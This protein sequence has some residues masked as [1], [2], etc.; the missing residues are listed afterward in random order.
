MLG[1]RGSGPARPAQGFV[2]WVGQRRT[3]AAR[4][5][6]ARSGQGNRGP[7][8]ALQPERKDAAPRFW[9]ARDRRATPA[10]TAAFS[11]RSTKRH[12]AS[13]DR[14]RWLAQKRAGVPNFK[15]Q[16]QNLEH[17]AD[18]GK[19]AWVE[20]E[21]RILLKRTGNPWRIAVEDVE[22]DLYATNFTRMDGFPTHGLDDGETRT[23]NHWNGRGPR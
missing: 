21:N 17:G 22:K 7:C 19:K 11:T 18:L 14:E 12:D 23:Q 1:L 9:N 15:Q 20:N 3:G 5:V 10:A 13:S 16:L 4:A 2:T 8:S 6:A